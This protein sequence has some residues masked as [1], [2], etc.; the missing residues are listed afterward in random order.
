MILSVPTP[1]RTTADQFI[2]SCGIK[3]SNAYRAFKYELEGNIISFKSLGPKNYAITVQDENDPTKVEQI[4]KVRGFS[5]KSTH[6]SQALTGSLMSEYIDEML[7]DNVK[8]QPINQFRLCIDK[9]SRKIFTNIF[10]K[11]YTNQNSC[12]KRVVIKNASPPVYETL[13]YGSTS[14]MHSKARLRAIEQAR[15]EGRSPI[16]Q[17]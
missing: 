3:I 9:K 6:A 1:D 5:L 11:Q 17:F 2:K 16:S 7:K 12:K 4:V 13:P 10:L 15:K 8:K 14:E